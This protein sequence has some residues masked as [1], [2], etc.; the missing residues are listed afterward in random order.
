M[1]GEFRNGMEGEICRPLQGLA[2]C[3]LTGFQRGSEADLRRVLDVYREA[4]SEQGQGGLD[5]FGLGFV[6]GV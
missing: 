3:A 2:F 6:I 1:L 4:L 5:F